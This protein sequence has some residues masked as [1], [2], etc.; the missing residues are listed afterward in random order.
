MLLIFK[1]S[2][3]L[4]TVCTRR[5]HGRFALPLVCLYLH[6]TDCMRHP[7]VI[8]LYRTIRTEGLQAFLLACSACLVWKCSICLVTVSLARFQ[9]CCWLALLWWISRCRTI[10]YVEPFPS[11]YSVGCGTHLT[12]H[13][14]SWVELYWMKFRSLRMDLLL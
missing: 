3:P 10:S 9:T 7:T 1:Y 13:S 12:C 2:P 4:G 6:S 8:V 11:E 14:I 5:C